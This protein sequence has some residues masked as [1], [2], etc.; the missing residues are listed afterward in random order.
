[1][2]LFKNRIHKPALWPFPIPKLRKK[3]SKYFF[4][5]KILLS[6]PGNVSTITVHLREVLKKVNRSC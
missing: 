4:P 6:Y 1:M 2:L 3:K 5:M